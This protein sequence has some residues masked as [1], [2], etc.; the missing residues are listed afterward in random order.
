MGSA[1][2][3]PRKITIDNPED[4]TIIKVTENVVERLQDMKT[5]K[6][7][8]AT[9][10]SDQ[11]PLPPK[12]LSSASA[13]NVTTA[14]TVYVTSHQIRNQIDA[15][16]DNNNAYWENRVKA[17]REGYSRINA[18]LKNEYDRALVE[19][20]QS[21]GKPYTVN[22]K[23]DT[24]SCKN[25]QQEVIKCYNSNRDRSLLCYEQV[26]HFNQCVSNQT[27]VLLKAN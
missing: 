11:S 3:V 13:D 1:K 25:T 23:D 20:K 16:I 27:S 14:A 5:P 26:K 2:S 18:E 22:E 24:Q 21:W 17:L 10:T 9:A 8:T 4:A 6:T 12:S 19:V 15:A 7:P